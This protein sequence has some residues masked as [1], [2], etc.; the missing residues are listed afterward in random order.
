M[1]TRRR[2][3]FI[4]IPPDP[5]KRTRHLTIGAHLLQNASMLT[6]AVVAAAGIWAAADANT[7][8][9]TAD[10]LAAEQRT[11]LVLHDSVH[12]LRAQVLA[13][14]A[15]VDSAPEMIMP[16][17][18]QVTSRFTRSRFHPLLQIFRPHRGVDLSAP[19]GTPIVAPALGTVSFVGARFGDG[20]TVE[21]THNG[22]VM[23]RFAHCQRILVKVG[24]RV[25]A[26]QRIA[27]VGSSG[28]TTGP[29]VHFEVLVRGTPV[30]PLRY[31]A[32]THDSA[33]AVAERL[34]NE[35]R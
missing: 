28:I 33:T 29:H 5:G 26:G 9:T 22:G 32:E 21:V 24:Q 4:V 10:Q 34:R 30:D 27:L 12:A 6:L 11:V 14:A 2:W 23:T 31:L 3:T 20:L 17:V 13:D 16:V 25:R 1:R 35:D 8:V 15:M 7:V 18:G 19:A